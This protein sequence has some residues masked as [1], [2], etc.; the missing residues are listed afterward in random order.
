MFINL[1]QGKFYIRFDKEIRLVVWKMVSKM[2]KQ[3]S[4]ATFWL[5]ELRK[6]NALAPG[7][8]GMSLTQ[9]LAAPRG[10]ALTT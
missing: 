9:R 5:L 2:A 6:K 4:V 3:N 7:K 8:L 10:A 1:K